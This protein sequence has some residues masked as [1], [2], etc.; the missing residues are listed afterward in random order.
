MT[1]REDFY[2]C[3]V[4]VGGRDCWKGSIFGGYMSWAMEDD[5]SECSGHG[6]GFNCAKWRLRLACRGPRDWLSWVCYEEII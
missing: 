3:I 4:R 2:N 5:S 6:L 1:G